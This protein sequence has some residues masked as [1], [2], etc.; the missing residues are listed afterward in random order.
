MWWG[1]TLNTTVIR[2]KIENTKKNSWG[3][4]TGKIIDF[5]I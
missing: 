4:N 1:D 5:Y 2:G 3:D